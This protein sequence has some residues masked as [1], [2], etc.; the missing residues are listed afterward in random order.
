MTAVALAAAIALPWFAGIALVLALPRPAPLLAEDGGIP[1]ALG[2]GWFA[3]IAILTLIMRALAFGGVGFGSA[4]IGGPLLALGAALAVVA[5]RR[6]TPVARPALR[7]A[8]RVLRSDGAAGAHRVLWFALIGWLV[9]RAVL[10]ASEV[11]L[12]PLYPWEAWTLWA[13]KARVFFEVQGIV[14]FVPMEAWMS[15]A[16]GVWFD[17]G[18]GAPLTV[19]L[20]QAW[21]CIVLGRFDDVLMNAPWWFCGV[22]LALVAFAALRRAGAAPLP[23]LAG[24][25]LVATLPLADA[26]VALAGYA[27][28]PLAGFVTIAGLALYRHASAPA[29]ADLGVALACIAVL[30]LVKS[31]GVVWVVAFVP[32]VAAT[33]A[34]VRGTRIAVALFGAA[35]AL[36]LILTRTALP[37]GGQS[38]H[39]DFAPQWIPF[40]ERLF[41]LGNW[42]LLWYAA[43]TAIACC[44]REIAAPPLRALSLLVAAGMGYALVLVAFPAARVW[45]G[46]PETV[47][48]TL[49]VVAPLTAIVLVLAASARARRW[50]IAHAA[51][52]AA[53]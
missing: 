31:A 8:W 18:P 39:L 19:P 32:A 27:D 26:H 12:R 11:L 23:A 24:M 34:P 52:A 20:L 3:G 13:T 46:E 47:N 22:A 40:G 44:W 14:P 41:L 38:L 51:P 5:A 6:E 1:W 30:P 7:A 37:I 50:Q 35:T 36:L 28:L 15:S 4:A 33:L 49:F 16:G 29:R 21:M 45:F 17:A 42:H 53:Q 43:V 48:R 2:A 9:L 25:G 10:L